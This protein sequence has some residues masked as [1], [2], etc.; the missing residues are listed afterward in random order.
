MRQKNKNKNFHIK[1]ENGKI[2]VSHKIEQCNKLSLPFM[3]IK[4]T[5]LRL[6]RAE[7]EGNTNH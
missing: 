7:A 1:T 2:S 5:I 3:N 6:L 4:P